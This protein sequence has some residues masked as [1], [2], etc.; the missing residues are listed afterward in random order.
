MRVLDPVV[1]PA[2][3][4]LPILG[5]KLPRSCPIGLEPIG[6]ELLGP[7]VPLHQLSEELQSCP[8]VSGLG[9]ERFQ[10]L[11]LV[12]HRPPEVM[13]DAIDP[14]TSSKCQRQRDTR[15]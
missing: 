14:H 1:L 9:D 13:L 2:I 4:D 15:N 12:V 8:L 5:T 3:G 11:A 10:H 7:P 6:D